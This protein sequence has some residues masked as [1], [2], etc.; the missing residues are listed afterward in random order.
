MPGCALGFGAEATASPIRAPSPNEEVKGS[1]PIL[2]Q[3]PKSLGCRRLQKLTATLAPF[4][5]DGV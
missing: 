2:D 1:F 3:S 4:G 5:L